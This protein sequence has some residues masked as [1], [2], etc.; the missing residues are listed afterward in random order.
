MPDSPASPP[1]PNDPAAR[2]PDGTLKDAQTPP[3]TQPESG[4]TTQTPT[5]TKPN[6]DGTTLPPANPPAPPGPPD[7]YDFKPAEGSPPYDQTILD[8][9]TPVF[10][11]LGLSQ[12][13]AEKL[14]ELWNK[15]AQT[16]ADLGV[17]AVI[18]QGE[19]WMTETK[20]DPDV[21]PKLESIK[22]DIGRAFDAMIAKNVI[23]PKDRS[24]F[25]QAMDLSMVGSQRAFIKIFGALAKAQIEGKAVNG[26]GP[27]PNGQQQTGQT[28]RPSA[29]AAM[30]PN[31]PHQ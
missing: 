4:P 2:T 10:K 22:T 14:V 27:S 23:T 24:E 7:K 18:A 8:A 29:A 31:L 1:L 25:L 12:P 6:V 28:T 26:A 11:E 16:Q 5:E 17:K 13:Q 3:T 30:Y 15:H 19:K 9:A 20:A 21:G